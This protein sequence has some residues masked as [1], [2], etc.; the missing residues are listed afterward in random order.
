DGAILAGG[1]DT[2]GTDIDGW[3]TFYSSTQKRNILARNFDFFSYHAYGLPDWVDGTMATMDA[4][5]R[6]NSDS[7]YCLDKYMITEFGYMVGSTHYCGHDG[8]ACNRPDPGADAVAVLAACAGRSRCLRAFYWNS[9]HAAPGPAEM[10]CLL[11]GYPDAASPDGDLQTCDNFK[12][13][14]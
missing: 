9:W 2:N 6:C 11:K 1:P 3:T 12:Y 10:F 7:S 5:Q 14:A 4:T 13:A 8:G